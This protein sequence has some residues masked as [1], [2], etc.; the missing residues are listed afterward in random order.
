MRTLVAV[1]LAALSL[2]GARIAREAATR[3]RSLKAVESPYAP[4]EAAAPFLVLGFREL[5][6]DLLL[7]RLFGYFGGGDHEA[8][9][10]AALAEAATALDPQFR[11]A[12]N[13]GPLAMTAASRGV[14]NEIRLRAIALL[15]RAARN[16]P[17]DHRYPNLAGQIYLTDLQTSDPA[18]RREWD[19]RGAL[20]LE[21]AARK[22]GAPADS[23]MHAAILQSRFGQKQRA[24]QGLREIL[25]ITSD[26]ARRAG[27]LEKLAALE[28]QDAELIA[29]ELLEARNRFVRDW[30]RQRPALPATMYLLV[31][32]PPAAGFDL[33]ALATGGDLIGTD[34]ALFERL[35]PLAP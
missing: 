14:D 29:A 12:Y 7:I 16:F 15:E 35:E 31:G 28:G 25:L 23:A 22:P 32:A 1:T 26:E 6:A 30:H 10:M 19:Q 17:A 27:I 20:L 24:I 33:A 9:P 3:Q 21:S 8:A 34:E 18:Q 4:S 5:G 2:G 11:R 13:V